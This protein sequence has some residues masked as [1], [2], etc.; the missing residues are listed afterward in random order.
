M[1]GSV[2]SL[3]E[4][5]E[6]VFRGRGRWAQ[7]LFPA[8]FLAVKDL[9]SYRQDDIHTN[10]SLQH[11]LQTTLGHRLAMLISV[12]GTE[13]GGRE[14]EAGCAP[15]PVV[16]AAPSQE[17]TGGSSS[18]V[19]RQKEWTS[20][21]G[22]QRA[23]DYYSVFQSKEA[24]TQHRWLL[25]TLCSVTKPDTKRQTVCFILC[26]ISRTDTFIQPSERGQ[27]LLGACEAEVGKWGCEY[28]MGTEFHLK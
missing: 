24:L 17:P 21:C 20:K 12:A 11:C 18:S 28:L 7:V 8:S 26:D 27:R 13:T 14:T 19:H 5:D 15:A 22:S 3:Q 4:V 1:F 16:T 6:A 10:P 9:S 2:D 23:R 25:K